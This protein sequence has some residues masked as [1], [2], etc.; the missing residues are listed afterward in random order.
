M[1]RELKKKF[2]WWSPEMILNF[3][4][5]IAILIVASLYLIFVKAKDDIAKGDVTVYFFVVA[6]WV[7]FIALVV[8]SF[9]QGRLEWLLGKKMYSGLYVIKGQTSMFQGAKKVDV[10]PDPDHEGKFIL[11]VTPQIG[12]TW[13]NTGV[14]EYFIYEGYLPGQ[15]QSKLIKTSGKKLETKEQSDAEMERQQKYLKQ[16]KAERK[17]QGKE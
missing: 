15:G 6:M 2:E 7:A 1:F 13:H 10:K 9:K 14:A 12:E 8:Y 4:I 3:I 17:K 11:I 16:L 5:V